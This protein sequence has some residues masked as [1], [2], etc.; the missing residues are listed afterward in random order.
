[1][2]AIVMDEGEDD[3]EYEGTKRCKRRCQGNKTEETFKDE[4]MPFSVSSWYCPTKLSLGLRMGM[5]KNVSLGLGGGRLE[6]LNT[7]TR[8]T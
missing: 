5:R 4:E 3:V 1:M 6:L 7:K 8:K 2:S